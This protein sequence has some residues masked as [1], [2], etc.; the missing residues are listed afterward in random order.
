MKASVTW[1]CAAAALLTAALATAQPPKERATLKGLKNT[2]DVLAVSPDGKTL[3]AGGS[4]GAGGELKLWDLATGKER[5]GF[6]GGDQWAT[7]VTFSPDGKTLIA[8]GPLA[9]GN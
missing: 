6:K 4:Y 9:G 3:V 8:S 7:S 5:P 1:L 2:I